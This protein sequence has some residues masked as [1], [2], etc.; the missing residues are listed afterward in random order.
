MLSNRTPKN[1]GFT[2]IELMI[3]IA[4]VAIVATMALPSFT[5]V[6]ASNRVSSTTNS[7]IGILNFARGEAV[8]RARTVNVRPADGADWDSGVLLWVD[9]DSDST[10]D[11]AEEVR[12][13]EPMPGNIGMAASGSLLAM[14]FRGN[15]Y[16]ASGSTTEF[17]LRI[18]SPDTTQGSAVSVGFSGRI[19][20]N[21][22]NCN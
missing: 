15:G 8:K 18:C 9:A 12:R 13:S 1:G 2:L 3:V 10:F 11:A 16:L 19:R 17:I 4:L 6:L 22:V 20:S 7:V 14:G 21:D 5:Q